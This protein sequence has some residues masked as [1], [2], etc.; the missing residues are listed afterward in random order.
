[1]VGAPRDYVNGGGYAYPGGYYNRVVV[2]HIPAIPLPPFA[3]VQV[4]LDVNDNR[5]WQ[6]Y[7][8]WP[9]NP[10]FPRP[11]QP[12][13]RPDPTPP[14]PPCPRHGG[15]AAAAYHCHGTCGNCGHVG[16][17]GEE[18]P[19]LSLLPLMKGMSSTL[20]PGQL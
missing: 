9:P 8:G 3:N 20:P 5:Y 14:P 11:P 10:T 16:C 19:S 1:V 18:V 17:G 6:M 15:C 7:G 12:R 13:P 4:T 2:P